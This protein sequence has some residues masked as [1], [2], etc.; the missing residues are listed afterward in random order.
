[1]LAWTQPCQ[2]EGKSPHFSAVPFLEV[3]PYSSSVTIGGK[4]RLILL[5]ISQLMRKLAN[6]VTLFCSHDDTGYLVKYLDLLSCY[7]TLYEDFFIIFS[8]SQEEIPEMVKREYTGSTIAYSQDQNMKEVSGSSSSDESITCSD[9]AVLDDFDDEE[10]GGKH[11]EEVTCATEESK[12]INF[13]LEDVCV[14]GNTLLW[15][16]VQ[17]KNAVSFIFVFYFTRVI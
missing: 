13:R 1:M 3:I 11:H 16:I 15:D 7:V 8:D 4:L 2:D 12:K 17:D 6:H 5:D 14:E 9:R 10:L